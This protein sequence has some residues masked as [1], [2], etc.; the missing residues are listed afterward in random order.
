MR[1]RSQALRTRLRMLSMCSCAETG[2]GEAEVRL[3]V[4]DISDMVTV[5]VEDQSITL[6]PKRNKQCFGRS[7]AG[8][9]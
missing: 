3:V 1:H 4:C 7:L 8:A 6:E 5:L 2:F 9:F